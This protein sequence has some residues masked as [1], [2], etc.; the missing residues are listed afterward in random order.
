MKE[1]ATKFSVTP[2]NLDLLGEFIDYNDPEMLPKIKKSLSEN[3]LALVRNFSP[4]SEEQLLKFAN[5][6]GV[7]VQ[8]HNKSGKLDAGKQ[9][10]LSDYINK[11][12]YQQNIEEEKRLPTQGAA[13]LKLHTGRAYSKI[14]PTYFC[15]L[16]ENP[17][18]TD[19]EI[20]NNG[21]SLLVRWA[22]VIKEY[23]EHYPA[24]ATNDLDILMTTKIAYNPW[25]INEE[26]D[27]S[28]LIKKIG[29]ND[30]MV[31]AWENLM[32]RAKELEIDDKN[33]YL[34]I[35]ERFYNVAHDCSKVIE[36]IMEQGMLIII[37]NKRVA[38]GRRAFVSE[39]IG[40]QGVPEVNPRKILAIG[41]H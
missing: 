15:M 30:Y 5:L 31:R 41:I 11:V 14:K 1:T 27:D 7:P 4:C 40:S 13:M 29:E 39:R 24:T 18:W 9:L 22:D 35:L 21:E 19:Y 32:E 25:Y 26:P 10:E 16:M 12:N 6:L 23:H 33:T 3:H 36:Y 37:D 2:R 8:K 20:G 38:H 17:G 28:P 34:E